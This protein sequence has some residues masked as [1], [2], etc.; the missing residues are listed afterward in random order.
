MGVRCPRG[1]RYK[2]TSEIEQ[3]LRA[4]ADDIRT[5]L[6]QRA[7]IWQEINKEKNRIS[8]QRQDSFYG[9]VLKNLRAGGWGKAAMAPTL[10]NMPYLEQDSRKISAPDEIAEAATAY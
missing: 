5:T 9:Q 3:R 7:H 1:P 4:Q 6:A 8:R 10:T 2:R